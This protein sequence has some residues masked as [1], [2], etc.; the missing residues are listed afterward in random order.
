MSISLNS[1]VRVDNKEYEVIA[2]YWP[3]RDWD[4]LSKVKYYMLK[5]FGWVP[6]K[7]Y[8]SLSRPMI[9]PQYFHH[10]D[11]DQFESSLGPFQNLIMPKE[12][13][14]TITKYSKKIQVV[15][16]DY[17]PKQQPWEDGDI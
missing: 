5:P 14:L 4:P 11:K 8:Y 10:I 7:Y 12:R 9:S 1:I 3:N 15:T 2:E 17:D 6:P 13:I 16:K